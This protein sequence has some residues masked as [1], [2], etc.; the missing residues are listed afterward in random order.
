M[1]N[2]LFERDVVGARVLHARKQI[3]PRSR[4][5]TGVRV[6]IASSHLTYARDGA[7]LAMGPSIPVIAARA[8]GYVAKII[9]GARPADL[10]IEL[11][12]TFTIIVNLRAAKSLSLTI[13]QSLRTRA[14]EVIE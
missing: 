6:P 14:D 12:S 13:P 3:R 4:E 8:A 11:P 10:P 5:V 1:A 9:E 7:L 2:G